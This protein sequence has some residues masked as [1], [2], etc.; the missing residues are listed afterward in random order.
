M[1]N[2]TYSVWLLAFCAFFLTSCSQD[3]IEE[4][5]S[6]DLTTKLAP[7]EYSTIEMEVL[8]LVN[9]YRDQK[10]L[11]QLLSLDEG[12]VQAASHNKHMIEGN[13]VCH[14]YFGNRYQALVNSVDA[15]A[16]SE[17]VGFGYRTADAVVN[18]WIESDGHRK[19]MEGEH[20]HFGI[21][22]KEGKDGKLYFTNIFVKK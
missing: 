21:S 5:E 15:K 6:A 4:L 14:H 16:V 18:A 8:D 1:K 11:S 12:S 13:E 22:V 3:S 19:N 20:T 7:V 2:L 10:G 9:A 17:N